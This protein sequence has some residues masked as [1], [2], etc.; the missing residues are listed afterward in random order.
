MEQSKQSLMN[1]LKSSVL[2]VDQLGLFIPRSR[3]RPA[4]VLTACSWRSFQAVAVLLHSLFSVFSG[5]SAHHTQGKYPLVLSLP[6]PWVPGPRMITRVNTLKLSF[7]QNTAFTDMPAKLF[8]GLWS[9]LIRSHI[10]CWGIMCGR[11]IS[12]PRNEISGCFTM[13]KIT[14]KICQWVAG[15]AAESLDMKQCRTKQTRITASLGMPYQGTIWKQAAARAWHMQAQA[16][17]ATALLWPR[18]GKNLR[19][20]LAKLSHQDLVTYLGQATGKD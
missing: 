14:G 17:V 9:S 2:K 3:D 8:L 15:N 13:Y 5:A 18:Q 11:L 1:L 10:I 20:N 6:F 12:H 19:A 16:S 4:A 7:P